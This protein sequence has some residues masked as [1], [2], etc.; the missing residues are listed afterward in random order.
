[1]VVVAELE[2]V[3]KP[4]IEQRREQ[5]EDQGCRGNF[6]FYVLNAPKGASALTRADKPIEEKIQTP[7]R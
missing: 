2:R 3:A 4:D 5:K 6:G 1:V 7:A